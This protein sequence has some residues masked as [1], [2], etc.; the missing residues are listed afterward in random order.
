MSG[1]FRR[2]GFVIL[3]SI[4]SLLFLPFA[5]F[6]EEAKI[7][8]RLSTQSP[9][10]SP[11]AQTLEGFKQRVEAN[12]KGAIGIE[13]YN[14]GKLFTDREV[15]AAVT[16]G[17]AEMAYVNLVRYA[18][19][20]PAVE[21]FQQPFVFNSRG[22]V[23]A[24]SAR[25]SGIRR[26]IDSAILAKT[27]SRV[28]WWVSEGPEVFLS[29]GASA[30]NPAG[31]AGKTVRT[32]APTVEALVKECGG[33]P[34]DVAATDFAKALE[35]KQVDL[36]ITSLGTVLGRQLWR[37]VD[38]LTRTNHSSSQ[39]VV[40]MNEAFLKSL[41]SDYASIILSAADAANEE[42][43]SASHTAVLEEKVYKELAQEHGMKI[44]DLSPE[45]LQ[46]WRICSSDVLSQFMDRSGE[47]GHELMAAYGLLRQQPCCG[48]NALATQ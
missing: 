31:I 48:A 45:E 11:S 4:V 36:A 14:S 12:S 5:L 3:F 27:Q 1:A 17:K 9:A 40:V 47:F 41:P 34:K 19:T 30:S 37:Y 18:G 13:I 23:A 6:A 39:F 20:V 2:A 10:G 43:A 29:N 16:A 8:I 24:A 33:N 25:E 32:Y 35:T 22:L 28:L 38:T 44:V 21:V 46:L 26:L 42:A 7:V 15:V